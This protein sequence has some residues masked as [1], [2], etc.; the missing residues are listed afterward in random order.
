MTARAQELSEMALSLQKSA[1]RFK[2]SE[3]AQPGDWG[4]PIKSGGT[5]KRRRVPKTK[6]RTNPPSNAKLPD[7]VAE[8]LKKRGIP[9]DD[10]K[11][12]PPRPSPK[13][14]GKDGEK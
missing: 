1:S 13:G 14:G 2:L 7:K 11:G 3:E 10:T 6:T 4:N 9:F 5:V 12:R 8:A